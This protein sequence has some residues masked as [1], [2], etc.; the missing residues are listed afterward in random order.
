MQRRLAVDSLS[1]SDYLGIGSSVYLRWSDSA[2][3]DNAHG[4]PVHCLLPACGPSELVQS[5]LPRPAISRTDKTSK[6]EQDNTCLFP[7][8]PFEQD[9]ADA[10]KVR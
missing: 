9:T 4:L 6:M 1:I 7:L 5:I 8:Y 10:N 3:A 2:R